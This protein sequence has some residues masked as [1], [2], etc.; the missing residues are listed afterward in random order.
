[1][2][3][4][5]PT[6]LQP[7]IYRWLYVVGDSI[8]QASPHP[9]IEGDCVLVVET[10]SSGLKPKTNDIVVAA[11][12]DPAMSVDRAGVVKKYTRA[13]LCSVSTQSYPSIPLK[14][15]KVKGIVVAVAKPV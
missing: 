4:K 2:R 13:G 15:A 8:N 7:R 3:E 1:M 12:L 6:I 14:K 9:L 5:Q 11:L 10:D